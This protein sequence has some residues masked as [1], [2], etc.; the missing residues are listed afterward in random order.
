VPESCIQPSEVK[1][2]IW[3]EIKLT[4]IDAIIKH[5]L[6]YE[7]HWLFRGQSSDKWFLESSLERML[8]PIGWTPEIAKLC[9]DLAL[10][11]FKSKAQLYVSQEKIPESKLGMLSMMQHHNIPTRLLDFTES[12]FV[13]L[14]FAF[15]GVKP[16][17]I[18]NCALWGLDYRNL[19][20]SVLEYIKSKDNSFDKSYNDVQKEQDEVFEKI[21]DKNSY[22]V[23][24]TTEP[25]IF[26]LRLE[27]QKGSFLV[28]GNIGKRIS[29]LLPEYFSKTSLKKIIIP[30]HLS[31][32]VYLALEQM[33]INNSRLF[34]DIDGLGKDI[35]NELFQETNRILEKAQRNFSA[36]EEV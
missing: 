12:P 15:D 36:Q 9:E 16:E 24:W 29:D 17:Q 25:G 32:K 33:G 30:A 13:A 7:P 26:N 18:D 2:Q 34:S 21:I 3:D 10:F 27:R 6:S 23:L 19:M 5:L 1:M 14:F 20:K 11:R 22:D 31:N 35:R 28:S 4:D 8:K